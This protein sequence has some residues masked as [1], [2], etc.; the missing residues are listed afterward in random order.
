MHANLTYAG[1]YDSPMCLQ[2]EFSIRIKL[3]VLMILLSPK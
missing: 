3:I 1:V 2:L